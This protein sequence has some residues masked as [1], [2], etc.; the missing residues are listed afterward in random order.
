MDGAVAWEAHTNFRG[1]AEDM[2]RGHE[3]ERWKKL[4]LCPQ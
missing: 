4:N 3:T 1:G 2:G